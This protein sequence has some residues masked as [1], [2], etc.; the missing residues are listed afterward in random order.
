MAEA[1]VHLD[2]ALLYVECCSAAKYGRLQQHTLAGAHLTAVRAQ[3]VGDLLNLS[4]SS[5]MLLELALLKT[6]Q[7]T[8]ALQLCAKFE[9][10]LV[11]EPAAAAGVL[12]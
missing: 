4:T 8:C 3:A 9:S 6:L 5:T 1:L 11:L 12:Q 2:D 10:V 7:T